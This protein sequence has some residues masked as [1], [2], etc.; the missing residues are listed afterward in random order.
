MYTIYVT[1]T[2]AKRYIIKSDNDYKPCSCVYEKVSEHTDILEAIKEKQ[3]LE[4]EVK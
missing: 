4:A 2:T 3:R 1:K